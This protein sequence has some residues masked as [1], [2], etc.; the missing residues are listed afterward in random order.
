MS[1]PSLDKIEDEIAR[2]VMR[3]HEDAYGCPAS[4][5]QVAIH[6][7]FVAV[8]TEVK[9]TPAE[10]TLVRAGNGEAVRTTRE[11]FA[12]V[13]RADYEEIVERATG[14]RVEAF[15]SRAAIEPERPWGAEIFLLAPAVAEASAE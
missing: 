3:V 9:L 14:R 13:I 8:V 12:H 6:D 11:E 4:G 7:T 1:T 10:E 2:E 15:A 5:F